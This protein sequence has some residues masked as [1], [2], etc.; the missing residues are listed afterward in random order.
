MGRGNGRGSG[1]IA[2]IIGILVVIY[3]LTSMFSGG[4]G[5]L[6]SLLFRLLGFFFW[7]GFL[8]LMICLAI[9]A[10]VI[11]F[12]VRD[13]KYRAPHDPP[14]VTPPAARKKQAGGSDPRKNDGKE[15]PNNTGQGNAGVTEHGSP[16]GQE[17][18]VPVNYSVADRSKVYEK[19]PEGIMQMLSDYRIDYIL[20]T[21]A[22]DACRQKERLTRQQESYR[23]LVERRFGRGTLS[24]EKYLSVEKSSNEAMQNSFLRIANRMEAFDTREYMHFRSG[25]YKYDS[26]P[27]HVQEQRQEIYEEN[28]RFM[29]D[30]LADNEHILAGMDR[31]MLKLADAEISDENSITEEIAQLEKQLEYYRKQL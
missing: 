22:S 11:Y 2:R 8:L 25:A 1:G 5:G 4:D 18:K 14:G 26:I 27:N 12:T 23:R 19:T 24:A 15:H 9:T 21:I 10:A 17:Q 20:G 31:L 13:N 7:G 16:Y 6:V 29:K 3:I 30:C 28:L